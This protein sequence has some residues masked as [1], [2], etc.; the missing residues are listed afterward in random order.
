ML[1]S[2]LKGR[3]KNHFVPKSYLKF[4]TRHGHK[5]KIWRIPVLGGA[6]VSKDIENVPVARRL[7]VIEH[8]DGSLDKSFELKLSE[9]ENI[10]SS[11]FWRAIL[12]ENCP[13]ND[14]NYRSVLTLICGI[15]LQRNP[16]FLDEF[17]EVQIKKGN[18]SSQRSENDVKKL[19]LNFIST[20]DEFTGVIGNKYWSVIHDDQGRF[21]TSDNP[22]VIISKTGNIRDLTLNETHLAFPMSPHRLLLLSDWK[23][24][25]G[26]YIGADDGLVSLYNNQQVI[27]AKEHLLTGRDVKDLL[28]ELDRDDEAFEAYNSSEGVVTRYIREIAAFFKRR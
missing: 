21:I 9:F 4:F 27:N 22:V 23:E 18:L 10:F 7:Y 20:V 28:A 5:G 1:N 26:K 17:R 12:N 2:N 15:M 3:I 25:D 14:P 16:L 11:D 24:I 8:A 19:W 6:I 13:L